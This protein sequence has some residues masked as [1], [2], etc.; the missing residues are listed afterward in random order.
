MDDD[1]RRYGSP[2]VREEMTWD[3]AREVK[4]RRRAQAWDEP[5]GYYDDD[6][7]PCPRCGEMRDCER[8]SGCRDPNC[9]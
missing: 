1:E 9:P 8:P 3:R 6:P 7:A 4:R 2:D 5:P